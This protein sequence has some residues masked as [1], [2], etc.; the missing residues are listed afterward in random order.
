[1]NNTPLAERMR[2]RSLKDYVGQ[3]KLIG[4]KGTLKNIPLLI[5]VILSKPSFE[6]ISI[7]IMLYNGLLLVSKA[8][9]KAAIVAEP[10]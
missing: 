4:S 10:T 1:M 2:P 7:P 8:L 3:E 9:D 6:L 5:F